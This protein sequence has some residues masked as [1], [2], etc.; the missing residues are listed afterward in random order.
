MAGA[1]ARLPVGL[2]APLEVLFR[3][4]EAQPVAAFKV[5]KHVLQR[6]ASILSIGSGDGGAQGNQHNRVLCVTAQQ[7]KEGAGYKLNLHAIKQVAEGGWAIRET[8]KMKNLWHISVPMAHEPLQ[9]TKFT[10]HF[11][12]ANAV[13]S[14]VAQSEPQRAQVLKN[15]VQ[16]C[17]EYIGIA[18]KL[19][20]IVLEDLHSL[21]DLEAGA[22]AEEEG[23]QGGGGAG[24]AGKEGAPG[25]KAPKQRSLIS[26]KEEEDFLELLRDRE[27]DIDNLQDFADQL[28]AE[29]EGLEAANVH[30]VLQNDLDVDQVLLQI[31][32]SL[33]HVDDLDQWLQVFSAKLKHMKIDI[34][35]IEERNNMLELQAQNNAA[36]LGELQKLETALRIPKDV[37]DVLLHG[38]FAHGAGLDQ[39]V[40]AATALHAL[41]LQA[42]PE[43]A[44]EEGGPA[45]GRIFAELQ[46]IRAIK[47]HQAELKTLKAIWISRAKDRMQRLIGK[48]AEEALQMTGSPSKGGGGGLDLSP[49]HIVLRQYRSL[50]DIMDRIDGA[51]LFSIQAAY[52]SAA[53][54]LIMR[55]VRSTASPVRT[56]TQAE[57]KTKLEK[58]LEA[59]MTPSF[60]SRSQARRLEELEKPSDESVDSSVNSMLD[61]VV[62]TLRSECRLC[63]TFLH[64][65]TF[66][67]INDGQFDPLND[68][69]VLARKEIATTTGVLLSGVQDELEKA[70]GT[71][72][73]ADP[74]VAVSLLLNLTKWVFA[75][76]DKVECVHLEEVLVNVRAFV[77]RDFQN[78]IMENVS[79]VLKADTG[80]TSRGTVKHLGVLP[81]VSKFPRL[82]ARFEVAVG[83]FVD[84]VPDDRGDRMVREGPVAYTREVTDEAYTALIDAMFQTLEK[85]AATDQKVVHSQRF[86]FENYLFFRS[87][88]EAFT[89][90][91]ATLTAYC[92]TA[93]A[94]AEQALVRYVQETLQWSAFWPVVKLAERFDAVVGQIPVDEV[95]FQDGFAPRDVN[96]EV[97]RAFGQRKE[98]VG[99]KLAAI[100]D[101]VVKHLGQDTPLEKRVWALL[102]LELTKRL[103]SFQENLAMCYGERCVLPLEWLERSLV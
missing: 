43:E 28:Q 31:D 103:E 76:K 62:P 17:Q 20:G 94:R 16:L 21:V 56:V 88:V 78:C 5:R 89:E 3:E 92:D 6:R 85:A 66:S 74:N 90:G 23:G 86:L 80:A 77:R 65:R 46:G 14:W 47:D 70:A 35:A 71:V 64:R 63:C 13:Q 67:Q 45:E 4:S 100:R 68:L 97:A 61:R 55:F 59:P 27:G 33:G 22:P 44:G 51:S 18:P 10:L 39:V 29:L 102:K 32:Q 12:G 53:T 58:L 11:M 8:W 54:P 40:E 69:H 79:R 73:R 36:L 15:L 84:A 9:Y 49:I 95:P 87:R 2:R 26:A 38:T 93:G 19:S 1:G 25:A 24:E 75:V 7:R 34:E 101:R 98:V 82:V 60:S 30:T 72:L 42:D 41:V 37:A 48:A 96:A 83:T 57:S 99:K 52:A 91:N 81:F 50:L